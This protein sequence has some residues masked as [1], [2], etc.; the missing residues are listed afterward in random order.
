M[1]RRSAAAVAI[2]TGLLA[3]GTFAGTAAADSVVYA[4][5]GDLHLTSPDGSKG[6][7]LTS[8]G[9]YSSPSQAADGTIGAIRDRQLVR[10]DRSGRRVGAPVD[11]IGS[12]RSNRAIAGPYEARLSPDGR[13][14]AYWFYVQSSWHDYETGWDWGDIGSHT[15][16]TYSDRF[17][18]PVGEGGFYKGLTQ[19]EW[20]T[21]DRLVGTE[22]FSMNMWTWKVGTQPGYDGYSA[23]YWFGLQDPADEYGVS[24]YHWYD[25]PALSPD[26]TKLAM[27]DGMDG[28]ALKLA[29]VS[30]P[31]WQGEPPYDNDYLNGQ[32]PFP[33]PELACGGGAAIN[34][35]WSSDSASL[36]YGGD[37]GVHVLSVPSLDC[38]AIGDR[39]VAPGGTEPAFGPA[40]VDMTLVPSSSPSGGAHPSAL[41]AVRLRPKAFR[42]GRGTR[43]TFTLA[44]PARVKLTVTR[45]ARAVKR[46]KARGRAGANRV[47]YR[48]RGLKPGRYRLTVKAA[49]AS[50]TAR[51]RVMR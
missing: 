11:V 46:L 28:H 16:W 12:D 15:A 4:K 10:L 37:D 47:R 24:A 21:N 50:R 45:G 22:G 30:G 18:D 40:D 9:G 7:R 49:G 35:S 3:L 13:R 39:L 31:V 51:F 14:F 32:T 48:G 29:S 26:G 43:V 19:G 27:T 33:R 2:A 34:P 17:T 1:R 23:Q 6:Y 8:D 44:A 25:D 20:L 36:A 38:G 5:A 42:A 41:G